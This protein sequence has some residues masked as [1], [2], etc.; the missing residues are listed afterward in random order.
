MERVLYVFDVMPFIHAGSVNK[1]SKLEYLVEGSSHC[2]TVTIP[3]GGVSLIFN[4]L[5]NIVGTG[6]IIF[7]CDRNPTI[8]KDMYPL[9]KD[10]RDH[11]TKISVASKV[12]EY[13]L[14]LCNAT[15]LY[16]PGYEADDF[17]YTFVKKY[18]DMYD[19]IYIY[20]GDSDLY[21]LVDEKTTIRPSSSN[22][23]L[24]TMENYSHV[25][26][27]G[28]FVKYNTSTFAKICSGKASNNLP[29][30]PRAYFDQFVDVMYSEQMLPHL[31]DKE[32]VR[33]WIS[34]LC[35]EALLQVDLAFPL[36]V[37]D[38]E[39]PKDVKVMDKN[40]I[41]NIGAAIN[42]KMYRGTGDN[43]YD[44]NPVTEELY[45]RGYYLEEAY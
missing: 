18:Y 31:G 29:P 15:L 43:G 27:K 38:E 41:R 44:V 24:V 11:K 20:T 9:Y 32:F 28:N 42:N 1:Y 8:K 21:F 6:D 45:R 12:A 36:D 7:C 3:T 10:N 26:S 19:K 30:L 40:T 37:P 17:I 25:I 4:E 2:Y 33:Y 14:E 22:A 13:I 39:L 16:A 35:P 5:Y 34:K 23:K